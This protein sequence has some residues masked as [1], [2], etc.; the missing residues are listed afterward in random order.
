M[1]TATLESGTELAPGIGSDIAKEGTVELAYA[2]LPL[3][4]VLSLFE[5]A[6]DVAV[7]LA[8]VGCPV[9]LLSSR[10]D[11]VVEPGSGDLVAGTVSGPVERVWLERS[12]HVATL[13]YDQDEIESRALAF[14]RSV[15]GR[16]PA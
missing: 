8:Q 7:D 12:Y 4:A 1:L 15:S 10:Q 16:A 3:A 5:A 6:E 9:L 2:E 14:A 13:D 11:H